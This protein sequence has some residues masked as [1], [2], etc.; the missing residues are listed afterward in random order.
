MLAKTKYSFYLCIVIKTKQVLTFKTYNIMST[1]LSTQI[2]EIKNSNKSNLNK[3]YDF[4]QIGLTR[5]DACNLLG[6]HLFQIERQEARQA[7]QEA[8]QTTPAAPV[9]PVVRPISSIIDEQ[10][11]NFTFG[12]EIECLIPSNVSICQKM[13]EAGIIN[14]NNYYHYNHDDSATSYKYM[15]DGSVKSSR[16]DRNGGEI[17]SPVLRDYNTLEKVCKVLNENGCKINKT[18]GLHVHIGV[19]DLTEEQYCNIFKNYYYMQNLINQIFAESR[20][21]NRFCKN[22]PQGILNCNTRT[23]I[24]YYLGDRYYK[25]NPMAYDRHKTIEFRGHQGSTN[26]K[27]MKMWSSFCKKL[28]AY[29][30]AGNVLTREVTS[31]D[32]VPFL[33]IEEKTYFNQRTQQLNIN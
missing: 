2:N 14:H 33:T 32:D 29:T 18:C 9:A 12:V 11:Q 31:F 28:V 8:R 3:F 19:A 30:K 4:L 1:T 22:L 10:A 16:S 24:K 7:R 5:N 6:V 17:V 27:K 23:R 15:Y 21:E 25:V 26:F 13:T 20:R